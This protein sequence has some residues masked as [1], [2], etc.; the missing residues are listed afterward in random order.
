MVDGGQNAGS[1]VAQ[2]QGGGGSEDWG[3]MVVVFAVRSACDRAWAYF[4]PLLLSTIAFEQG[5]TSLLAGSAGLYATRTA[6]EIAALPVASRVWRGTSKHVA[7]FLAAEHAFLIASAAALLTL[8]ER[9]STE[10]QSL[11]LLAVCGVTMAIEA[12]LSKT[13]WNAVEKQQTAVMSMRGSTA[14]GAPQLR[15]AAANA[16]LSRIDLTVGALTPFAV[17]WFNSKLGVERLL[18]FLVSLQVFGAA[19]VAPWLVR[20]CAEPGQC[21]QSAAEDEPAQKG[22]TFVEAGDGV[23]L[24]VIAHALLHFTVVSPG[25]LLLV[26]LRQHELPESHITNF[27]A[28]AQVRMVRHMTLCSVPQRQFMRFEG[29]HT[30][31]ED[32]QTDR[33]TEKHTQWRVRARTRTRTHARTRTPH[34]H[35]RTTRHE[36]MATTVVW[37]PRLMGPGCSSPAKRRSTR[38]RR[39]HSPGHAHISRCRRGGGGKLG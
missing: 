4:L 27:V 25:G 11:P 7:L 6:V 26:W 1:D 34:T 14:P 29:T 2:R 23:R 35:T 22:A 13:L 16:Q 12:S 3:R 30:Q 20:T 21:S 15:L 18:V 36:I 5:K 24:V 39:S 31:S 17:A 28:A 10:A 19:V 9:S 32:R 33:Q 38:N 8:K 37:C